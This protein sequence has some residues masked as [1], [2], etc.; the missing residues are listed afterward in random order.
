MKKLK[1]AS[2]VLAI[3][4]VAAACNKNS[5]TSDNSSS[6]GTVT[7]QT[8][9]NSNPTTTPVTPSPNPTTSITP[10]PTTP[11][12]PNPTPNPTAPTPPPTPTSTPHV[13]NFAVTADD[14]TATPAVISVKKGDTVNLTLKVSTENV[15]YG[16]LDFR[17]DVV[18]SGGIT[19]GQS[20]T[21]TFTADQ[22][23]T[24]HCFW[25]SSGNEK[26]SQIQVNV[27]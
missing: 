19:P 9:D 21:V 24:I 11:S 15:Y 26:Q 4:L 22:S 10:T 20:K 23:F 6:Q 16:G 18:N 14:Y 17:S 8:A 7:T 25:P 12:T 5:T 1:I 27:S 13:D 3:S 2:L